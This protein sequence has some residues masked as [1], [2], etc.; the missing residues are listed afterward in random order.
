MLTNAS[1]LSLTFMPWAFAIEISSLKTFWSNLIHTSS[2][3]VILAQQRNFWKAKQMLVTFALGTIEH[4]N[5]YLELQIM[6]NVLMS[7]LLD[8]LSVNFC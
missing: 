2:T 8:A 6:E 7:G 5:L 3:F 4:Q 1:E